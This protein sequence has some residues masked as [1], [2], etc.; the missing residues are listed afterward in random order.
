MRIH[1]L[2]CAFV[3]YMQ[4][5]QVISRQ[6]PYDGAFTFFVSYCLLALLLFS[7]VSIIQ[8]MLSNISHSFVQF[9]NRLVLHSYQIHTS[10]FVALRPKSTAMIMAG[11]SVHLTT[12]FL[13]TSQV[14]SYGHG[15]TVSSPNH[16]FSWAS[17]NKQL[18]SNL[19]TYF[20]L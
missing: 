14:N 5:S 12:L 2:I 20:H 16:T 9:L 11:L 19:C 3:V 4:Q 18:T 1:R 7:L 17:L 13:F 6:C 8:L 15:G 10:C